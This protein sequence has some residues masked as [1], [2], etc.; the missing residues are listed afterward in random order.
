MKLRDGDFTMIPAGG[1]DIHRH[2]PFEMS[3]EFVEYGVR[4]Q[5]W[6]AR[7]APC[8]GPALERLRGV[9]R[10]LS[11]AYWWSAASA[12]T[13]I[14]TDIPPLLPLATRRLRV[15]LDMPGVARLGLEVDLSYSPREVAE[16]YR[17]ERN[18]LLAKA[19][20]RALSEK[21]MRLALF[22]ADRD[23]GVDGD[24]SDDEARSYMQAWNKANPK[25]RYRE[26]G[27]FNRDWRAA[28]QRL[29]E[30]AVVDVNAL[31]PVARMALLVKHPGLQGTE[32][33]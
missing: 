21:H 6:E 26:L 15:N 31:S 20:V 7:S 13:F 32:K 1:I 25:Q 24:Q 11:E 12:A 29:I 5:Q 22:M 10:A 4:E 19:R 23:R 28:Q 18:L 14:L 30:T 33:I 27:Q 8:C 9:A 16:L 2:G 17:T 3:N